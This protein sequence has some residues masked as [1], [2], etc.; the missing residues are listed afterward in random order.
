MCCRTLGIWHLAQK[1]FFLIFSLFNIYFLL[2]NRIPCHIKHPIVLP[3]FNKNP[4]SS[5]T[6]SLLHQAL[7]ALLVDQLR[8][9]LRHLASLV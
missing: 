4:N 8:G 5:L 6:L 1:K 9:L 2:Y 7:G 3:I